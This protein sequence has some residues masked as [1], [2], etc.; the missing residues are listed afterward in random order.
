MP[1]TNFCRFMRA[2][3]FAIFLARY[4]RTSYCHL[5]NLPSVQ[6]IV[7]KNY[8]PALLTC[9]WRLISA[10]PVLGPGTMRGDSQLMRQTT[11][12]LLCH[13]WAN[14]L[15]RALHRPMQLSTVRGNLHYGE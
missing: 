15:L 8:L 4:V 10:L 7:L 6:I 13:W 2:L 14:R 1:A 5:H 9:N 12:Q 11:I 3:I